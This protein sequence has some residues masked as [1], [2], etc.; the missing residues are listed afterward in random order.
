VI[1]RL[2]IAQNTHDIKLLDSI[3][4]FFNMGYLKPKF[5][6]NNLYEAKN[7]RSV[8]RYIVYSCDNIINFFNEF[9]MFGTKYMD[10]LD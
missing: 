9:P 2:E 1:I 7:V 6:I 3:K 4:L 8:S 5:D 10:Y